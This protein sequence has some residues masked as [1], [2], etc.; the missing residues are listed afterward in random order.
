[1]QVGAEDLAGLL[2]VPLDATIE[3][4]SFN[5]ALWMRELGD[6]SYLSG[7]GASCPSTWLSADTNAL[8]RD[9]PLADLVALFP[10]VAFQT[11]VS[12]NV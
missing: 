6:S 3:G 10:P 2:G 8:L 11:A 9:I 5:G 4:G 7:T 12:Q 1:M